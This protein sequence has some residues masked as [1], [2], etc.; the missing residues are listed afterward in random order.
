MKYMLV[1]IGPEGGWEDATEQMKAAMDPWNAY[2]QELVEA[3]AFVAGEGLQESATATTRAVRRGRRA[4]GH[5]RPFAET[6]EQL[7]GFYLIECANLDEALEW[8]KKVPACGR[9]DRG[10]AGDGLL[11]VRLGGPVRG[12]RGGLLVEAT[13]GVVDR[14]FRHESGRAVAT[15]IRV[16]GDFDAAEEAVQEAF[17]VALERWPR[18]GLPDNPGAWI[19]R[20]RAQQGDRPAA[21]RA[22]PGREARPARAARGAAGRRAASGGRPGAPD[23]KPSDGRPA[24]TACG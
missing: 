17:V 6:K 20:G 21:P 8:A 2:E 12:G 11:A 13:A 18:D 16:L 24:T 7:G 9:R 15:L 22:H 19:T 1:L 14:T 5:R 3:G 10:A 4:A 23:A